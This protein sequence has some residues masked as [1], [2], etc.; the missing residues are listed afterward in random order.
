MILSKLNLCYF[1]KIIKQE[2]NLSKKTTIFLGKN[3][4][5]KT[6]ILEAIYLLSLGKSF[7]AEKD[8]EM[9]AFGQ[10]IARITGKIIVAI[11]DIKPDMVNLE[12]VLTTGK[13]LEVK[14]QS[15]RFSVNGVARRMMDFVG[16]LR[17]ALFWPQDLELITDSPSQR[18]RYLDYVLIQID[19]E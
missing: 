5:G 12:L 6:S 19:K 1:R 7:R 3:T 16:R 17:V 11:G 13:V 10:D 4:C 18:R 8:S 2:F 14:T 9:I 15:K